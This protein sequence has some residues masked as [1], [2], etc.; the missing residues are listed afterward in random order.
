LNKNGTLNKLFLF[1]IVVGIPMLIF[2]C[3]VTYTLKLGY[4]HDTD[5]EG[6]VETLKTFGIQ[7]V[8]AFYMPD[9]ETGN[10]SSKPINAK[11]G[12]VIKGK[13]SHYWPPLG[14]PNCSVFVGGQCVARM[15]SGEPW[16]KWVGKACACPS[17][18]AFGTK[19]VVLGKTYTCMDRGG[20]IVTGGQ[21]VNGKY[22][23]VVW[24]DLLQPTAPVPYGTVIDVQMFSAGAKVPTSSGGQSSG[25]TKVQFSELDVLDGYY[26]VQTTQFWQEPAIEVLKF[27]GLVQ[28]EKIA[29]AD[30][31]QGENKGGRKNKPAG[32][33]A[34]Y[35]SPGSSGSSNIQVNCGDPSSPCLFPLAGGRSKFIAGTPAAGGLGCHTS[36]GP[37][38]IKGW[39]YWTPGRFS[40]STIYATHNGYVDWAGYDGIGNSVIQIS[41][42]N[43]LTTYMHMNVLYVHS[44]QKVTQGQAIGRMGN[45]GFSSWPHL[46]YSI[47]QKGA[48]PVCSQESMFKK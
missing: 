38:I 36:G 17:K 27:F 5:P 3:L 28:E 31:L 9:E 41:N 13:I 11:G 20:A 2:S 43:W 24:L 10:D 46:H 12:V 19:W 1:L 23:T 44:G 33:G 8:P 6:F 18:Y 47:Y 45:V 37:N 42:S 40:G 39:D 4:Q 35:G 30:L 21:F 26:I 14:G 15:A 32:S 48:G 25:G 16:Q 29:Y 22:V 34:S 7:P